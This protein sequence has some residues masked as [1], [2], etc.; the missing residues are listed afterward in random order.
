M[1]A[2]VFGLLI[3]VAVIYLLESMNTRVRGR[4]D[5]EDLTLRSPARSRCRCP[6]A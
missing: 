5:L 4:K 3:P 6:A 1:V 2:L